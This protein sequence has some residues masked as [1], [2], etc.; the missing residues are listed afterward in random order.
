MR[1]IIYLALF[2]GSLLLLSGCWDRVEVNDLAIITAAAIDKK[3][4]I[5][6]NC[7]SKC[8]SQEL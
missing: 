2:G 3:R 7:L 8:L 4:M 1:G 6:L 5:A